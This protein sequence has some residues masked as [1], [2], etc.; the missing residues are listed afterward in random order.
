MT[1]DALDA[2]TAA[3]TRLSRWSTAS[4]GQPADTTPAEFSALGEHLGSCRVGPRRSALHCGA[5]ALQAFVAARVVTC[6]AAVALLI[7]LVWRL[8]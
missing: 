6:G 5:Q 3:G 7:A 1:R 8:G 4:A 2:H